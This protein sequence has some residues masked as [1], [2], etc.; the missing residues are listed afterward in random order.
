M[1]PPVQAAIIT[2]A[3]AITTA[4]FTVVSSRL[5]QHR[6]QRNKWL[7]ERRKDAYLRFIDASRAFLPLTE[8]AVRHAAHQAAELPRPNTVIGDP[9]DDFIVKMY[10]QTSDF[11]DMYVDELSEE[12][13]QQAPDKLTKLTAAGDHVDME[14][15]KEI[16]DLARRIRELAHWFT[17][18]KVLIPKWAKRYDA[19][20]ESVPPHEVLA[21]QIYDYLKQA[22][23]FRRQAR[24]H[25][26]GL[27]SEPVR[28]ALFPKRSKRSTPR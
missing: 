13:H 7:Y 6:E 20:D 8:P 1:E 17:E 23:D 3:V 24:E 21:D 11:I 15:P 4:A 28:V 9:D 19:N 25:L 18:S 2:A 16:R 10:A 27:T 26:D 12:W 14:G 5:Q 22:A